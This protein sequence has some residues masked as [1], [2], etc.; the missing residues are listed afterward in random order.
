MG[1]MHE[2][3]ALNAFFGCAAKKFQRISSVTMPG[4]GF[5]KLGLF[6]VVVGLFAGVSY[7]AC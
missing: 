5:A 1:A 3:G 4:S 7:Q 2:D 6:G